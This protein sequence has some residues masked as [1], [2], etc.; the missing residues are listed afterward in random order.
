MIS[1]DLTPESID[2]LRTI[3][4]IIPIP[5]CRRRWRPD[6]LKSQGLLQKESCRLSRISE[7]TL[8]SYLRQFQEGGIERLKRLDFARLTIDPRLATYLA[9]RSPG[10]GVGM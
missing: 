10:L 4:S 6:Y 9:S 5:G 2:A 8:R 7:N 1:I 3:A